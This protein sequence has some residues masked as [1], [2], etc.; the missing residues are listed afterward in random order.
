M[1]RVPPLDASSAPAE[2]RSALLGPEGSLPARI[3]AYWPPVLHG[4][5][6]MS[7]ALT[8]DRLLPE[9]L[10]RLATL[11]TALIVGCPY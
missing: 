10:I 9:A 2:A 8:S 1:P 3:Q 5:A 4:A 6:A 11:R 7:K